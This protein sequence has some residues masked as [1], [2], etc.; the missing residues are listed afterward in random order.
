MQSAPRKLAARTP[1]TKNEEKMFLH[2]FQT[3]EIN[4]KTQIT[5]DGYPKSDQIVLL[6]KTKCFY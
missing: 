1:S 3:V 2:L 6:G 5:R 4:A